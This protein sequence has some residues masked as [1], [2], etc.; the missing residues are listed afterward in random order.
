MLVGVDTDTDDTSP[1]TVAVGDFCIKLKTFRGGTKHL[2]FG[3][4]NFG[5]IVDTEILFFLTREM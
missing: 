2:D 5:L 3:G 1:V 4:M